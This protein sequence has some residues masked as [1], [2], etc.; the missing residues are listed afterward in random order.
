MIGGLNNTGIYPVPTETGSAR[1]RR[2]PGR[3]ISRYGPQVDNARPDAPAAPRPDAPSSAP[4]SVD[5]AA[6]RRRVE[7]RQ[8]ATEAR[9]ERFQPDQVSLSN[10]RA[11]DAFTT[12]AGYRDRGDVELA[13]V[14]IRV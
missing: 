12:V 10:S 13:G 9:L 2:E 7:A 3:S 6:I 4:D 1:D 8:A 5:Q 14:D 11:L